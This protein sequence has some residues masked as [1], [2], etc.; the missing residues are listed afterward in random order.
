MPDRAA[1]DLQ[2]RLFEQG[3]EELQRQISRLDDILFRIKAAAVTVWLAVQGWAF[4]TGDGLLLWLGFFA[5]AGFWLMEGLFR[6]SQIGFTD[7]ARRLVAFVND[8]ERLE[9]AFAERTFPPDL[10]FPVSLP[11]TRGTRAA[12]F[13]RGLASPFVATLY[14][15]LALVNV[16]AV[17]AVGG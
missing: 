16:L 7:T 10:V 17:A 8:P 15:V 4:S 2:L 11:R 14:L 12:L 6:G 5:I 3:A 9:R 13:L 1:F